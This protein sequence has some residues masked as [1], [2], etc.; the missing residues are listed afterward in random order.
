MSVLPIRDRKGERRDATRAEIL[1]AAWALARDE[2]LTGITLRDLGA[3]VGLRA[4][5]LYSYFDSKFAI[6]DAMFRQGNEELL[7]RSEALET[8]TA[9]ATAEVAL[10]ATAHLFVEF[11]IEEPARAWLMFLRLIPGFEPSEEA[12]APAVRVL[13]LHM[14]ILERFG[15][16]R[17]ELTDLWTSVIAGLAMQQLANDPGG[18]RYARLADDAVDMFLAHARAIEGR[19]R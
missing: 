11:S 17:P 2:G 1:E 12:Y 15:I 13:S 14:G 16:D 7:R 6:Y 3:R 19:T 10:R 5:S 8:G 18:D 4:Q 9:D